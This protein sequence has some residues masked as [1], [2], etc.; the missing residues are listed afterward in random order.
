MDYEGWFDRTL[1]D[2]FKYILDIQFITAMGPPGGGRAEISNRIVTKFNVINFT[3]LSDMQIKRIYQSILAFKFQ[4]FE[5]EIKLLTEP[6]TAA[7]YNLFQMVQNN[8]LPTPAKS[9]YVFN[10][11]D[12]SKVIQGVY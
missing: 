11:R 3:M 7:T 12:I 4:E 9:H 10:M 5:D 1:R 6:I 2:L 8:F